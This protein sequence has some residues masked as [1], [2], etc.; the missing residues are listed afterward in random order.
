[1]TGGKVR[2]GIDSDPLTELSSTLLHV[3]VELLRTE[4]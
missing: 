1:M 4:F 3:F 2:R